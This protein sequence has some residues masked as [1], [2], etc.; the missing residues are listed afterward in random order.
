[1]LSVDGGMMGR[2]PEI[3]EDPLRPADRYVVHPSPIGNLLLTGNGEQLM[4]LWFWEN[5]GEL[6]VGVREDPGAFTEVASQLDEYFAGDRKQFDLRLAPVG[7]GFNR[8]VWAELL[9][10][11]YG[12]TASYGDIARQL[13]NPGASRA[14]G[15]ANHVNPIAIIIPCHRIIGADGGMT[16]Y[17]GGLPIKHHLLGLEAQTLF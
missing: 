16:G 13:G 3:F 10:V 9:T 5:P 1:M 7:A 15:S 4:C 17:A 8:R 12:E 11:T 2:V 6:P 14:V